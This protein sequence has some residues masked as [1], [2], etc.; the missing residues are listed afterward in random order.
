MQLPRAGRNP[1][2]AKNGGMTLRQAV[3]GIG[4]NSTRLLVGEM[5]AGQLVPVARVREGTRLF[6]GLEEGELSAQSMARCADVVLRFAREAAAHGVEGGDLFITATCAVRDAKNGADFT[7]MIEEMTGVAVEILGGERE[8]ALSFRGAVR[9]FAGMI[10]IGGGSTEIAVGGG[11]WPFTA[12][13]VQLGA[14]RLLGEKPLLAGDGVGE[15]YRVARERIAAGWAMAHGRMPERWTGVGGTLTCLASIDMRLPIYDRDAIDGHEMRR[16]AV[17]NWARRLAKMTQEEREA[18]SGMQPMRADIIAHG[19]I[20]LWAAMDA[21]K[22]ERIRATNCTN[23]DGYLMEKAESVRPTDPVDAVRG[24]YDATVQT[25]WER[26]ERHPFEFAINKHYLDRYIMPGDRV[27]DAGGG[28]GRYALHLAGR[29][30]KVTLLDLSQ[31]NVDFAGERARERGLAMQTVCCDV[32]EARGAVE[33]TFDAVLLMGP[34]Y[35]LLSEKDRNAAVQACLEKLRPGGLL[36]AAFISVMGGMIFGGR[37]EPASML[38]PREE[39]FYDAVAQGE[40]FAGEGFT[41]AFMIQPAHVLP[42]MEQFSLLSMHLI[43]SEGVTAP[44][45]NQ[46]MAAQEDV[47]RRWLDFSLRVCEREDLLAFSEHLLYIGR[48]EG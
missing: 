16:D 46:M 31:G 12:A 19:V 7:R 29:G 11:G 35:H 45:W 30:A 5:R 22:I 2:A 20:I 10:D 6:A 48:K 28:P 40:D 17:E 37:E 18:L 36:F 4:S 25:E 1:I 24:Y 34:L 32:R 14:V 39:A 43:G 44:F 3:I 47:R 41:H 42:F 8:A 23:L 15:A 9:G 27:L 21:L 26:L 33:G 38:W 13:S